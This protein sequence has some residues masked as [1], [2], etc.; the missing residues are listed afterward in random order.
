MCSSWNFEQ[1]KELWESV[2]TDSHSM[3]Y[4]TYRISL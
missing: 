2:G 4:L 1:L 3:I